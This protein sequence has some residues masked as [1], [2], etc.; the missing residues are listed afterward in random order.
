[1]DLFVEKEF[2]EEFELDYDCSENKSE[3]QKIVF[4]VFTEFT[5]IN[6]FINASVSFINE[7]RIL[8]LFSDSNLNIKFNVDFDERFNNQFALS[9]QT[10]IFTKNTKSWFSSVKSIGALCYNYNDYEIDIQYFID[11][12]HFK[13]DLSQQENIPFKWEKFNFLNKQ[14]NFIIISDHHILCDKDGQKIGKNLIPLLKENLDKNHSYS[15][16]ILTELAEDFEK[17]LGQLNSAL[18][19][20]RAKIYL[21]HFLP[22]FENIDFH[23]RIL[24][25]N[26]TM[27]DSGKGFNLYSSKPKNSQIVNASIFEKY[28]FKRYNTHLKELGRYIYKLENK[29]HL[30]NPYRASNNA[31]KAFRELSANF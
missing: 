11:R 1:M 10:L 26:Y 3:I 8:S 18:N 22:E 21:F 4:S 7:S 23:D 30:N 12:T 29:E 20:Y 2:I 27:T 17:K 19:G 14:T 15:I 5:Q 24:Y 25:S 31:F 6:L 9:N 13:I 28:T 16:F